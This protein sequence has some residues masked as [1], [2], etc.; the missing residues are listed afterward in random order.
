METRG[1]EEIKEEIR[2]GEKGVRGQGFEKGTERG[3]KLYLD[4]PR[5]PVSSVL[6]GVQ[7]GTI[8]RKAIA[9]GKGIYKGM[10]ATLSGKSNEEANALSEMA[11]DDIEDLANTKVEEARGKFVMARDVI[12]PFVDKIPIKGLD[13]IPIDQISYD[14]I[15]VL[16]FYMLQLETAKVLKEINPVAKAMLETLENTDKGINQLKAIRD[17][18]AGL[19][20]TLKAFAGGKKNEMSRTAAVRALYNREFQGQQ[21]SEAHTFQARASLSRLP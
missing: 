20:D 1:R 11:G 10:A 19:I 9:K 16:N 18:S 15:E 5:I 7:R 12:D 3:K 13:N 21:N 14:V 2:E 8:Q 17:K 6:E 4:L